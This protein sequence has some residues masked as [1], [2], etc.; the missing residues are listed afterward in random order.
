MGTT[1]NKLLS[2]LL[3]VAMLTLSLGTVFAQ[4]THT[5]GEEAVTLNRLGL[6]KGT[7]QTA[8]VPDLG[9]ALTREMGVTLLLRLFGLE[10]DALGMT[11]AETAAAL[12][13]FTDT[14]AVSGWARNN[15]A[16]AVEN[17]ILVGVAADRLAPMEPLIGKMYATM[18]LRQLGHTVDAADYDQAA[19]TLS[20]KG[21]VTPEEAQKFNE[22]A[23]IRDDAVGM[24]F[25][26][27]QAVDGEGR[28]AID[29]LVAS[30]AVDGELAAELGVYAAPVEEEEPGPDPAGRLADYT[31]RAFGLVLETARVLNSAGDEVQ[32]LEFLIGKDVVYVPTR[33]DDTL[34][35]DLQAALDAG[36][37]FGLRMQFGVV[38]NASTSG[39]DFAGLGTVSGFEDH[40]GSAWAKV[41]ERNDSVVT[42]DYDGDEDGNP[43]IRTIIEGPIVYRAKLVGGKVTYEPGVLRDIK[44]DAFV[45]LYTVSGDDPGIVE[46]VLVSEMVNVR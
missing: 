39:L 30:G 20:D 41:L 28:K 9:G 34:D 38:R 26:S 12:A 6:F 11:E 24:T 43:D 27:L 10:E 35:L 37:L 22:K 25:G 40:T 23:L 42:I 46:V 45:R 17:G 44:A 16:Y 31:G 14:G 15:I 19:Q 3:V 7:S 36:D 13:P 1:K 8:F 5:Y 21:G 29:L 2:L 4:E 33:D 32:E 18:I